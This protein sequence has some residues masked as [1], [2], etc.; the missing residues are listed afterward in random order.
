M[1]ND[2]VYSKSRCFDPFPFPAANDLQK[3]RIRTIAGDLDAHRKRVLAEHPHLTLT[4][5]YNVLEKLRA[6]QQPSTLTTE[7]RRIFDDGL[8][9]ILKEYHDKLDIAVADA[10]GWPAD[11]PDSEILGRLVALNAE[12]A[13]EESEGL[14]RWLRPDYQIPRFGSVKDKLALTGGAMRGAAAEQPSGPKP[15][16]PTDNVAQTAAV[17]AALAT[18]TTPV[19]ADALATGFRQGRR[20]LPQIGSVLAS[21]VRMGFVASPDGGRTFVMRRAA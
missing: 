21:L 5:L 11:L 8:V 4:G 9:L 16:F 3:H 2:P 19:A 6:G 1:G 17:M 10:Y 14:V 18:S 20:A 15:S 12:R 7:D 13:R